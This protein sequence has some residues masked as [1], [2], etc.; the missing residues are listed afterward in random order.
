MSSL[1][2]RRRAE[3]KEIVFLN[4]LSTVA[5]ANNLLTR[6]SNQQAY[7]NGPPADLLRVGV[8]HIKECHFLLN[9]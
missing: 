9:K 3:K 8:C 5:I 2:K 7:T 1:G 4:C 6:G